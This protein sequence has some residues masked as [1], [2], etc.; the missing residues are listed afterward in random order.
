MTCMLRNVLAIVSMLWLAAGSAFA[1]VYL[2]RDVAVTVTADNSVL[3]RTQAFDEARVTAAYR[4]IERLTMPQDRAALNGVRVSPEIASRLSSAVDV[5]DEKLS[6]TRYVGLLSVKFDKRAVAAYLNVYDIPFVDTQAAQALIIP[7]A[8]GG[9]DPFAWAAAWAKSPN[10]DS[11]TP[12]L[13]GETPYEP[14]PTWADVAEDVLQSGARRALV[15]NASAS[16]DKVYVAISELRPASSSRRIGV[17]GPFVTFEE[18]LAG[19]VAYSER[20]WKQRTVVR[21]TG[22]TQVSAIARFNTPRQWVRIENALK[23]SRLVQ[24]TSIEAVTGQGADLSFT[25]QGQPDQLTAELRASGVL[26]EP[27]PEGWLLTSV[28]AR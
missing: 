21:V 11:L 16:E 24:A 8:T 6:G 22:E 9:I 20:D 19:V 15:V 26:L 3:A 23:T 2:V 12:Y 7:T 1:D 4:L 13:A 18:A 14:G 28:S 10:A 27:A 5:Q 17:V 25:F